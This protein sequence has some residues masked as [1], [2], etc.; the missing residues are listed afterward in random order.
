MSLLTF[1]Y[2]LLLASPGRALRGGK[3]GFALPQSRKYLSFIGNL[4]LACG[5]RKEGKAVAVGAVVSF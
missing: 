4:V 3:A 1:K 2:L 5:E